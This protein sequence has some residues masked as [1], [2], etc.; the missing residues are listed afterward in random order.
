M[1]TQFASHVSTTS[2]GISPAVVG[3]G[4]PRPSGAAAH[5]IAPGTA[6]FSEGDAADSVFE[7]VSGTLRLHK[8]LVD[9]RRQIIGFVSG[10]R[11]LGV[12]QQGEYLCTAEALT[13]VVL[14]RHA[15]AAFNRRIDE[16]PGL[17][18]LLLTEMCNEL[19]VAQDQML[20][21]GRKS[22]LE[23]VASFLLAL[24]IDKDGNFLE[25][26]E[27]PMSRTDIAD[28]LGLTTET[29]SRTFTRLRAD[30]LIALPCAASVRFLD[31]DE[32]EEVAA[33]NGD[34]DSWAR[35]GGW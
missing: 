14:R 33:G 1:G 30:G 24:A 32:L 18:R 20:L 13:P 4:A 25:H 22:A 17:A 10:G 3:L 11:L 35:K 15:R 7:V 29:V 16:E 8:V 5:Q 34:D 21:L 23:K 28:Y 19:R 26:V 6:V 31:I 2:T 12:S 27:L 9:G